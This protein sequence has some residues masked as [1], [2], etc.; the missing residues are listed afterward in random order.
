VI[1]NQVHG[2]LPKW[3][4]NGNAFRYLREVYV[5]DFVS[6]VFPTSYKQLRYVSTGTMTGI[7]DIFPA[8]QM[9]LNGMGNT[10]P[11]R[12]SW[13]L[14]SMGSTKQSGLKRQNELIYSLFF[15]AESA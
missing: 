2:N 11:L 4:E 7:H 15:M 13:F 6:L 5:D 8:I 9:I 12:Q 14:T 1:G 10:P 3:D